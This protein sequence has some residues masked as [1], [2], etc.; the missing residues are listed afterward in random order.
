MLSDRQDREKDSGSGAGKMAKHKVA[1]PITFEGYT[2]GR[3]G[4]SYVA[5]Y[6]ENGKRK[7][8]NLGKHPN[9]RLALEKLKQFAE[10]RKAVKRQQAEYTIGALWD[11]W[12][13]DRARDG[14]KNDIY[15]ANW[16]SLKLFFAHRAPMLL[17]VEDFRTYARQRFAAGRSPWTV[18]TELVRL[19]SCLKWAKKHR[20][21]SDVPYVWVCSRGKPRNIV[22]SA[23]D[24]KALLISSAD[25]L[26]V[27][28]FIV[29][30]LTTAARHVAILDLEWDRVDFEAGTI[31]YE[32]DIEIDPMSKSWRKGRVKIP[33]NELA[34]AALKRAY[35][36]RQTNY[37]VEY[38]GKRLKDIR[39]SFALA[40]GAAGLG[41]FV[42]APTKTK[43]KRVVVDTQITPHTI[44]H[45]VN[46]WL[47]TKGVDARKRAD[48]LGQKDIRVNELVYSHA[49][50]VKYLADPVRLIDDELSSP[51]TANQGISALDTGSSS[52]LDANP[53]TMGHPS[54]SGEFH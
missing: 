42:P 47:K 45:S 35:E 20:L 12:M 1:H 2:L 24:A 13:V 44:R 46:S 39:E 17:D 32:D 6:R 7:R 51:A 30:A 11:L 27:F 8:A 43:P 18:N 9:D 29:L 14:F 48:L 37:V 22:I 3:R 49:D 28:V 15:L 41:K 36:A 25:Q 53:V 23:D 33:M 40:V 16:V 34:R 10:A 5:D 26:H 38:R 52:A 50:N 4:K 19:R 21:L 54:P 31:D